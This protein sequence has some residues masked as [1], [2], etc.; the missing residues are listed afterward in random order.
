M[1]G[2]VTK[3]IF[4]RIRGKIVP[5]KV[6]VN[7]NT[8]D[9]LNKLN[10]Q[11][12]DAKEATRRFKN[13]RSRPGKVNKNMS[14]EAMADLLEGNPFLKRKGETFNDPEF[15][16]HMKMRLR[17]PFFLKEAKSAR[18]HM[19]KQLQNE[20]GDQLKKM[21]KV[22][23]SFPDT[24]INFRT[25]KTFDGKSFSNFPADVKVRANKALI[26]REGLDSRI[27][28]QLRKLLK[29]LKGKK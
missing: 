12:Q 22:S 13:F 23:K 8:V 10:K 21:G 9:V 24:T 5:I 17:E 14:R 2:K 16:T 11:V 7:E 20:I 6:T 15:V 29:G 28:K 25:R 27:E 26:K 3:T 18:K 4:R 19:A 1:R